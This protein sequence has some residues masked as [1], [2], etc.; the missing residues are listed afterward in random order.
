MSFAAGVFSLF[1]PGN[2]VVT[3]TTI[4]SSTYN[5]TLSDIATG[6]ST[7]LLKDGTQTVTANIPMSTFIFTGLGAGTTSGHSVRYEQVLLLAGG[8]MTG[9][10]LFT[11][12]TYDIGAS[13]ATRPRDFYLSRNAVFGGTISVSGVTCTGVTGTGQLVFATTPTLVTPVLGAA[14]GTSV[15]LTGAM[16]SATAAGAVVATQANMETGTAT[17]LLVSP[18]RQNFHPGHPK[19]WGYITGGAT[20][21]LVVSYNTASIADTATGNVTVTIETDFSTANYA[22]MTGFGNLT[23]N[24][25][26]PVIRGRA[27]GS[28]SIYI[29]EVAAGETFSDGYT[30]VSFRCYGDQA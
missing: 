7:A 21:A 18:G 29:L 20:P 3:D 5:S 6:L 9:N 22:V 12:A 25:V 13:G 27:A 4:S 2:P 11:D 14:T 10:L 1:T 26:T 16:S 24:T 19:A 23:N 8:T 17:N 28:F 15:T 30:D